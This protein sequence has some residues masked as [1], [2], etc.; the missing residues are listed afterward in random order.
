MREEPGGDNASKRTPIYV[1]IPIRAPLERVW[2]LSQDTEMHPRWDLRFSRIVPLRQDAD[3]V[4]DFRYEFHLPLH[5]IRGTGTS[6]GHRRRADGQATSVLR[7]DT[8]DPLS[9]IG[10]GAGYWRYSPTED[11][12]RFITGY[13]YE[14]GMGLLGRI[15]DSSVIRPALGW[16]TAVGFDRLRLWAE[17]D[18]DPRTARNR[19][20]LDAGVRTGSLL[21]AG[22]LLRRARSTSSTAA[23]VV[24]VAAVLS[25]FTIPSHWTVPRARRCLR[26][27]PDARAARAPSILAGL[28]TS[29]ERGSGTRSMEGGKNG[30]DL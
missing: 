22:I 9:P 26:R 3:G 23:A 7:F 25:A 13:N 21:A 4:L 1:E 24:G 15:L 14:P 19:W 18:V 2:H 8:S 27:A 10:Q 16:A 11:G 17:S 29:D 30:L 20:F 12:V 28:K 5:I 6:L